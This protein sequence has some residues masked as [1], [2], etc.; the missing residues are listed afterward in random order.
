MNK[1]L[2]I[3]LA[4]FI[5]IGINAQVIHTQE[6][7]KRAK[8]MYGY[9]WN[10]A[11]SNLENTLS[12]DKNN[13]IT[14]TQIIECKDKTK[15]QLY[16]ILN[17]W[18]TQKFSNNNNTIRVNNQEN[19]IIMG[20]GYVPD[21]AT[22]KMIYNVSISPIVNVEIIDKGVRATCTILYYDL[23][24]KKIT[25]SGS[26]GLYA[27]INPTNFK[28]ALSDCFP[29]NKAESKEA[30]DHARASSK[31]LVMSAAYFDILVEQIGKVLNP[32]ITEAPDNSDN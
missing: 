5:S 3:I 26:E 14:F 32:M 28:W 9:N 25:L 6:L 21:V 30:D 12:L 22:Y 23:A 11:A 15:E 17:Q 13:A 24:A 1:F 19:G 4:A 31:A 10:E 20:V 2:L 29:F 27:Q 16:Y 18:F 7:E 8:E